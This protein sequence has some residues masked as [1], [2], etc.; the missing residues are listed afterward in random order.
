MSGAIWILDTRLCSRYIYIYTN[1]HWIIHAGASQITSWI[2]TY[3]PY[4][5]EISVNVIH[6]WR[7]VF[8]LTI[9]TGEIRQ[10][11]T[12]I[13]MA[14]KYVSE[15]YSS[16]FLSWHIYFHKHLLNYSFLVLLTICELSFL[17][18]STSFYKVVVVNILNY[19]PLQQ[20]F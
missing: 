17:Y 13:S 19:L 6:C 5:Q 15:M 8:S 14:S 10:K 1:S 7:I 2:R 16:L 11:L 9:L 4:C 12:I 18:F 20:Q 3:L